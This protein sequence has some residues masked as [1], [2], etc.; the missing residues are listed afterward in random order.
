MNIMQ[1]E[2]EHET[3]LLDVRPESAFAIL[4]R[5][6]AV[7]IP[8]EELAGRIHEL[9]PRGAALRVYDRC[10]VRARW[11]RSRLRARGRGTPTVVSGEAW[12]RSGRT[13]RGPSRNRLWQPHDL[14]KRAIAETRRVW[15]SVDRR[16][17]LDLA[18]GAGR[19]AV[20]LA[21]A[22]FETAAWDVLPDAL[23]RCRDLARR[24]GVAVTTECRDVVAEPRLPEGRFDLVCVFNF[25]HRPLMSAIAAAV[26]PGGFVV[27][28]T[29][30]HPQRERFGKPR[31]E[32]F[33]LQPGELPTW[34]EGWGTVWSHE[35]PAGP[36]R[37]AASLIAQRPE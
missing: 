31:R 22:G 11:A 32:A 37:I 28:E 34:F 23:E 19:D 24:C 15:S 2:S 21:L 33:L 5:A 4:H 9:P 26:R 8:L 10:P 12:L 25:L 17:A 36:R 14:L 6:G 3:P 30:V 20:F 1:A 13:A 29:F 35:G 18:C 16:P 27:Y 7:N